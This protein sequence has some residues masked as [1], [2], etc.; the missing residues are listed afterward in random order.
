MSG[1]A[2]NGGVVAMRTVAVGMTAAARQLGVG[3]TYLWKVLTGTLQSPGFLLKVRRF[4]PDLLSVPYVRKDWKQVCDKA[5]KEY[6]WDRDRAT[7]VKKRTSDRRAYASRK[8]A[9]G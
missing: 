5:D 1:V 9:Q 8:E 4:R 2:T 6:Y 7:Y 3:Y